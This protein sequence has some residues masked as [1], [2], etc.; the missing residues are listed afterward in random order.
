MTMIQENYARIMDEIERAC[1]TSGRRREDVRFLAVT[2][3][4]DE[5]RILE[6]IGCGARLVGE[7]RA[8]ELK[9]K[10]TFFE[11][12]G[13]TVHFI[14]QLQ[15]NKIK[16]VCGHVDVIESLDRE[17][18]AALLNA[19]AKSLGAVQDVMVQVNI[20]DEAHKG[21]IA[22]DAVGPFVESLSACSNLRVTGL[23][24]VPPA[25]DAEQTRP[26]FTRMRRLFERVR[27]A[28]PELP[29]REL[30][31][32]MSHDYPVA[33]EEGATI[34]RVGTALFGARK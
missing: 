5:A 6:A 3:F 20:G 7:N 10:L 17:E 16:Y 14:G 31:M 18:L 34:V 8:Q 11:L 4:V 9:E 13:C 24:C 19:R 12:N 33:I 22:A 27:E 15:T 30:S 28:F 29:I 32:G 1:A 21:G 26:Y 23:M 25:G 2:K